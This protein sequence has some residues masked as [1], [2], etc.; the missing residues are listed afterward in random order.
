[1]TIKV[2]TANDGSIP[3]ATPAGDLPQFAAPGSGSA[4]A[5]AARAIVSTSGSTTSPRPIVVTPPSAVPNGPTLA[6]IRVA[7]VLINQAEADPFEIA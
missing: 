6:S 2:G 5:I 4:N 7:R 1:M 3:A